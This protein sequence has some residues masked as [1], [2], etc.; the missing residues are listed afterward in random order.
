M[1]TVHPTVLVTGSNGFTGQYVCQA[2][3][4]SGFRWTGLVRSSPGEQEIEADIGDLNSLKSAI[5]GVR[6]DYVIHLAGIAFVGYSDPLEFYRV[7]VLGTLNLLQVLHDT[8]AQPHQIVLASSANI[9]GAHPIC[10]VTEDS[11]PQPV[12]HYA[13]SKLAMEHLARGWLESF[14]IVIARPFNYTGRGQSADFVIPKMVRHYVQRRSKMYLGNIDV[15]REFNDVRYVARAYLELMLRA[16]AGSVFNICTGAGHSVREITV[17]LEELTGHK[18]EIEIDPKLVRSNEL[19][20]LV[21]DPSRLNAIGDDLPKYS[22]RET[23]SNMLDQAPE[24]NG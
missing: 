10:P 16:P 15:V 7:N 4:E 21:G 1:S 3:S 6:P 18:L 19:P 5:N 8:G 11:P 17:C 23:L 22:L 2:L 9:Y 14:P 24:P 13:M 20:I 12:N